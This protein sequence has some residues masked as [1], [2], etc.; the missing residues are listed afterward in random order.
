M[1]F[2]VNV[3]K[4]IKQIHS[5]TKF[6]KY[7]KLKSKRI[8]KICHLILPYKIFVRHV[9]SFQMR[10]LET[11]L[12]IAF[13]SRPLL[14]NLQLGASLAHSV[15][16]LQFPKFSLLLWWLFRGV[17]WLNVVFLDW[18]LALIHKHLRC[19]L[20]SFDVITQLSSE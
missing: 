17:W 11:F 19:L 12:S 14:C 2:L 20:K 15:V 6:T 10:I 4:N 13:L 8:L 16:Y 5:I 18:A 7:N 9:E 3:L 1:K